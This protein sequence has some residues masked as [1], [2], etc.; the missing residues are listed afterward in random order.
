[1][2]HTQQHNGLTSRRGK[3][4]LPGFLLIAGFFLFIERKT[5]AALRRPGST[6]GCGIL[7]T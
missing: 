7:N 3:W 1:M 2:D 5:N 4:V 6:H